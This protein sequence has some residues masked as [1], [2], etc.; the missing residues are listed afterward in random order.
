M[1]GSGTVTRELNVRLTQALICLMFFT[2]A[3]SSD[4]VGSVIPYLIA[5]FRL[6]MTA[7][8]AFHYVPMLAIGVGALAL[9][10]LADRLGPKRTIIAGL[11]L[12]GVGSGLFAVGNRF[13]FFVCL[14]A[15][16]GIGISAFK[17]GGL[18]LVGLVSP[19]TRSHTRLMNNAEGFFAVG[20]IVGPALVAILMSANFSWKWLYVI[21]AVVCL[22]LI[23]IATRLA[24]LR[25][26]P[27]SRPPGIANTVR[28]LKDPYA[29][30]FSILIGLYV[31]VE[32]A[33]YVWMPTYLHG[34]RES[35]ALLAT[36][37]LTL[38]FILRALGRFLAV[39]MLARFS[40]TGVLAV[41]G[42][43]IFA[44]FAGAVLGGVAAGAWLLPLSGLFMS[45]I[46]PTLNSKGICG[47]DPSQHGAI[48]GLILAFTA[49]AA[50]LGPLAMAAVSDTYHDA[51]YGFLLATAFALLLA[52][53]LAVNWWSNPAQRR[54]QLADA[55]SLTA[56]RALSRA[57]HH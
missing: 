29:L 47:Y 49:L 3:M 17:I 7:A 56:D 11:V 52:V 31:A 44:C 27:A 18:A 45:M 8:G 38:F 23:A 22:L 9:G 19:T 55:G 2:F 4:A 10:P 37:G 16:S 46:Y 20:S 12:Y 6:S 14:L 39:W 50:A 15:L 36:Y 53:G 25:S 1:N 33:I 34:L 24:D 41:L 57:T 13:A 51:K 54:L 48:A 5:D 32:V 21:C 42:A 28:L 40:W 35:Y 26:D 43:G 30:F